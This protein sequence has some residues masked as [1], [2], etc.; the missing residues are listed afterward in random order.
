[1][2]FSAHRISSG[3]VRKENLFIPPTPSLVPHRWHRRRDR[4]MDSSISEDGRV[5]SPCQHEV[6]QVRLECIHLRRQDV[7]LAPHPLPVYQHRARISSESSSLFASLYRSPLRIIMALSPLSP[8]TLL[9]YALRI[10]SDC[11]AFVVLRRSLFSLL[12]LEMG[13]T[14]SS[15]NL[16]TTSTL[17]Q[18]KTSGASLST[19]F[20]YE[21]SFA[22][23]GWVVYLLEGTWIDER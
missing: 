23:R 15:W 16:S 18:A 9:M 6:D 1:M 5:H 3:Q 8:V 12:F 2:S 11:H 21:A 13:N 19:P 20:R 7:S 4:K 14:R 10:T 17:F 22:A